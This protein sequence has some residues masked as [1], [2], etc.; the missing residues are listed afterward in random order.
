MPERAPTIEWVV[1]QNVLGSENSPKSAELVGHGPENR[2]LARSSPPRLSTRQEHI[3]NGS[4]TLLVRRGHDGNGLSRPSDP[5][6][7]EL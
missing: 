5:V 4:W 2:A 3:W 7:W 1:E 6:G